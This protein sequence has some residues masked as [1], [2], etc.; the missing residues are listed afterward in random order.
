MAFFL[1]GSADECNYHLRT[2]MT[3]AHILQEPGFRERWQGAADSEGLRGV[4]LLSKRRRKQPVNH[5]STQ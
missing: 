5:R 1:A 2:L 3:I 4:I